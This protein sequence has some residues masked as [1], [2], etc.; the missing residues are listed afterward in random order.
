MKNKFYIGI[1]LSIGVI[2]LVLA[3]RSALSRSQTASTNASAGTIHTPPGAGKPVTV[4][5]W[6]FC[7]PRIDQTNADCVLS[8]EDTNR[9]FYLLE[10]QNGSAIPSGS[11]TTGSRISVT[12]I[13]VTDPSLAKEFTIQGVLQ[14]AP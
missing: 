4:E 8:I 10:D 2:I 14:L 9:H 7:A 6:A 11:Y 3:I 5:G 13:V 1:V 12:G